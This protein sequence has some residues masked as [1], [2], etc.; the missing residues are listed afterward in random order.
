MVDRVTR[1]QVFGL[2]RCLCDTVGLV[3]SKLVEHNTLVA[4]IATEIANALDLPSDRRH[5]VLLAGMMHD[6]GALSSNVRLTD[7]S[8]DVHQPLQAHAEVGYQL[9]TPIQPLSEAAVLVRYHH[10]CWGETT[11]STPQGERLPAD[12]HILHLA[13]AVASQVDTELELSQQV[14]TICQRVR[15][16]AGHLFAPEHVEAFV[17]LAQSRQFWDQNVVES[18]TALARRSPPCPT[19]VI[20]RELSIALARVF[21]QII[22]FRSNYTATHGVGVASTAEMLAQLAGFASQACAD[23]RIAGYL[24]DL[25]KLAVPTGVLEKP[26][27]LTDQEFKLMR[28]HAY[29]SYRILSTVRGFEQIATWAAYHHER[30]DG[31]GYP[32]GL[33]AREIPLGSRILSVADVYTALAEDRPYREGLPPGQAIHLLWEMVAGGALD[34]DIVGLLETAADDIEYVRIQSQ[35]QAAAQFARLRALGALANKV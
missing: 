22:D 35:R 19:T 4:N 16:G 1:A 34:S 23:M 8:F 20:D 27:G 10:H 13:D 17:Q 7:L 31:R 29:L 25:G 30:L 11:R 21:S 24:H 3:S 12:G 5:N 33:R 32:F 18:A 15:D 14:R 26:S 6:I 9:L 2:A 28:S